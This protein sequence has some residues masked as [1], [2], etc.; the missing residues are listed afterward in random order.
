MQWVLSSELDAAGA[1]VSVFHARPGNDYFSADGS[2]AA[3]TACEDDTLGLIKPSEGHGAGD[4]SVPR[5][6][7]TEV[8]V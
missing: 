8:S 2:D 5:M 4:I 7:V 3:Y 6:P 1:G